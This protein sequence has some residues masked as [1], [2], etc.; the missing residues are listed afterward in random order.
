MEVKKKYNCVIVTSNSEKIPVIINPE[1]C[2]V[3]LID[4]EREALNEIKIKNIDIF[5]I[6]GPLKKL[7]DDELFTIVVDRA[8]YEN[9]N[10]VVI[11]IKEMSLTEFKIKKSIPKNSNY[12]ITFM[13]NNNIEF[14]ELLKL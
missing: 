10:M 5:F 3:E 14:Q 6:K 9:K 2:N 1:E 12:I 7:E 11:Q 4:D 13:I 8:E